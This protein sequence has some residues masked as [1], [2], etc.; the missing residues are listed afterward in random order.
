MKRFEDRRV[1]L[2]DLHA[3]DELATAPCAEAALS[4]CVAAEEGGHAL[5]YSDH[6]EWRRWESNP[7]NLL[8][9]MQALY[10]LSYAPEG[11]AEVTRKGRGL[12]A[13]THDTHARTVRTGRD[14]NGPSVP[15]GATPP[16]SI[17]RRG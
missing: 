2:S 5:Q 17:G 6:G 3:E 11:G 4:G 13:L 7:R 14:R 16:R 9:A 8:H 15:V 10:Q 1:P 12:R